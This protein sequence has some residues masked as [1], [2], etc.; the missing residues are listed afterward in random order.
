MGHQITCTDFPVKNTMRYCSGLTAGSKRNSIIVRKLQAPVALNFPN[1]SRYFDDRRAMVHFW[2]HD[3]ALE[4]SFYIDK[5][6]LE[7]LAPLI[8]KTEEEYLAIFDTYVDDVHAT[9]RKVYSRHL[10]DAYFLSA[11]DFVH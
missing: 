1:I 8:E 2:G 5:A 3:S 9:A 6:A 10:E 7:S 11:A 4:I